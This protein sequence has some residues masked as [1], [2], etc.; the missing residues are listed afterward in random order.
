MQLFGADTNSGMIRKISD[1]FRMN[2][3]P[4]L[5]PGIFPVVSYKRK[6]LIFMK[7]I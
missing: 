1:W 4:K 7:K 2:F 6:T 5:A 3:N